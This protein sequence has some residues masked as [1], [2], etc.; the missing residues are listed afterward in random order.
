MI[1]MLVCSKYSQTFDYVLL[2]NL[3]QAEAS[4]LCFIGWFAPSS[5]TF[6]FVC[7]VGLQKVWSRVWD[8]VC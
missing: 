5:Q 3:P 4:L 1:D 2:G 6:L 7:F 8:T